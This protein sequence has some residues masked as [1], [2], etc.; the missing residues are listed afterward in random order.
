MKHF[1]KILS[2]LRREKPQPHAP[3]FR[4]EAEG[5]DWRVFDGDRALAV[6]RQTNLDIWAFS[7]FE[8]DEIANADPP[9]TVVDLHTAHNTYLNFGAHA[10]PEHWKSAD[11]CWNWQR[12]RG[13][14]L[15]ADVT[16]TAREGENCRWRLSVSYDPTWGR[17][18]YRIAIDARKRDP[19]G[20]ECFNMMTAGAL[21]CRPEERRWTHS[22]WE[23]LDGDLRR[24][25]H[26]NALFQCTDY[27]GMRDGGGPWR[28]YYHSY[29]QAWVGYAAHATFNPAVLI[30]RTTVPLL[31]AIC[32]QLFDEHVIWTRAGQ[33]HLGEDGYFHYHMDLEFV[34]VPAAV[35]RD[36]LEQAAD[37]VCPE[38]WWDQQL[39]LPLRMDVVNSFETAVDPW[40]PEDCPILAVPLDGAPV[41][42][43]DETA[44]SGERSVR[45]RQEADGRLH[46]FPSGAVC[47]VQPHARYRLS[48]WVKT[49]DVAEG[50]RIELAGY[51]YRYN[52]ISHQAGS[53]ALRGDTEWTQLEVELDSGEQAYLMPYLVLEGPGTAWFDDVCLAA[54]PCEVRRTGT[55]SATEPSRKAPARAR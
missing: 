27:G 3:A 15:I 41:A 21:A 32:S 2:S 52:N 25:A 19:D 38:K 20:F 54:I 43:T 50:A 35:A 44:H 12:D 5:E 23:N 6:F 37:P 47:R 33:S 30:H 10:W 26:S 7:P 14:E 42:W 36:L 40:Q 8:P 51:A 39:A 45:L 55:A 9:G 4:I 24:I 11:L 48:A 22:V 18:R 34:N 17:Y 46:L 29:P 28:T 53:A 31:G 13:D 1:E 49:R 16:V